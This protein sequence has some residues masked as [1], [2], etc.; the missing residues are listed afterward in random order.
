MS[1]TLP[2]FLA[3]IATLSAVPSLA[4]D[5]LWPDTIGTR[6]QG[7]QDTIS[8][9]FGPADTRWQPFG[10]YEFDYDFQW[11]RFAKLD[12][13]GGEPLDAPVGWYGTYSRVAMNVARGRTA[14]NY[15]EGDFAY[16]N[17]YEIGYMTEEDYGWNMTA[18]HINGPSVTGTNLGSTVSVEL[19]R[20]WRLE[21][22]HDGSYFE[23][24]VGAR[25]YNIEDRTFGYVVNN[26]VGGQL[27]LRWFKQK[28]HF[29]VSATAKAVALENYQFIEGEGVDLSLDEFV[30]GGEA[31]LEL[32]YLLSEKVAVT[33]GWDLQYFGRGI[34]RDPFALNTNAQSMTITGVTFGFAINR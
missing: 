31:A 29:V 24:F 27:G 18:W 11:W 10:D 32:Q 8:G 9:H 12:E 15:Y 20:V 13:Y 25:Y 28:G 4:Q 26:M 17:R 30:P 2:L 23:P 7:P 14:N 1:R 19:N 6:F 21:P 16:G 33:V 22:L 34:A 5:R 3:A